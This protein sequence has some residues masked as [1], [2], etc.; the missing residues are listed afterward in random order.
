MGETPPFNEY[1]SLTLLYKATQGIWWV[2]K[3]LDKRITHF[4]AVQ[5]IV[6]SIEQGL[7][8][9]SG[10]SFMA[11]RCKVISVVSQREQAECTNLE[12]KTPHYNLLRPQNHTTSPVGGPGE[13]LHLFSMNDS[14]FC[15]HWHLTSTTRINQ[16]TFC[17][18]Y[19]WGHVTVRG[20]AWCQLGLIIM[21]SIDPSL[22]LALP[23]SRAG[24]PERMS[25][26]L[27]ILGELLLT[28]TL[29]INVWI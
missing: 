7:H 24:L 16:L 2:L 6:L 25:N 28:G 13:K 10:E 3:P 26:I 21:P 5:D 18:S 15:N 1:L 23:A 17:P 4:W 27:G 19:K 14:P 22:S 8:S 20:Y 12:N 29:P 9:T 11:C